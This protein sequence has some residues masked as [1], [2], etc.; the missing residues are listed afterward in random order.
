MGIDVL[1]NY[2]SRFRN[3]FSR[4]VAENLLPYAK[5]YQSNGNL[6]CNQPMVCNLLDGGAFFAGLWA[7]SR[8][9]G[10]A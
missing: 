2:Y 7:L 5:L 10:F 6:G 3:T 8:R 9:H 4:T 1:A